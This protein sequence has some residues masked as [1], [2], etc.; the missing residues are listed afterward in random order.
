MTVELPSK[1][2]RCR[3]DPESKRNIDSTRTG[4]LE[5]ETAALEC[6]S[7]VGQRHCAVEC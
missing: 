5:G 6:Y 4:A 7:A 2:S 1:V 3:P